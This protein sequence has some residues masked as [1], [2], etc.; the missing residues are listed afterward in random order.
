MLYRD[1]T[2]VLWC[3]ES[4][5]TN[6]EVSKRTGPWADW[7]TAVEVAIGDYAQPGIGCA[8]DSYI[9]VRAIKNTD[10]KSYAWHTEDG[11]ATWQSDGEIT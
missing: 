2:G 11:G 10:S 6:I 9:I 3:A 5:S 4:D 8:G 7:G 1:P